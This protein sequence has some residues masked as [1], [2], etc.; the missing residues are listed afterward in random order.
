MAW[1]NTLTFLLHLEV[2]GAAETGI[3]GVK[4]VLGDAGERELDVHVLGGVEQIVVALEEEEGWGGGG[5]KAGEG[6]NQRQGR[7]TGSGERE[8]ER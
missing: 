8:R 6:N 5:S 1:W 4:L 7:D 2:D 3:A